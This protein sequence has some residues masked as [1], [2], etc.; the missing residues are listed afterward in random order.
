MNFC[1]NR[2]M[3]RASEEQKG[4]L[5]IIDDENDILEIL[6]DLLEG[7]AS[8]ILQARNGEE[9]IELLKSH[10][11]DAILS[12]EKMPKKSGIEVLRWLREHQYKTPFIIHT[13]FGQKEVLK[14][15]QK[16]GVFAVI[17][18][19]WDERKLISTVE[20]ALRSG[21]SL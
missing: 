1:H 7:C 13:G 5:L 14:E 15:A 4:K 12:D 18:K 16:W 21:V 3:A 6:A 17:D 8:D 11:I 9:A 10:R 20:E 19:P 2:F